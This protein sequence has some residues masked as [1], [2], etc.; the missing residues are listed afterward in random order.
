MAK[1]EELAATVQAARQALD[2]LDAAL[3]RWPADD[4]TPKRWRVGENGNLQVYDGNGATVVAEFSVADVQG[5]LPFL[6]EHYGDSKVTAAI[7]AAVAE[8]KAAP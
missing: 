2:D 3:P 6:I 5:A 7:D 8:V 1:A 4:Q